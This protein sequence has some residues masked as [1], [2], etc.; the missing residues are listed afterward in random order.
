MILSFIV[1]L[2][3]PDQKALYVGLALL[4]VF[5]MCELS[6]FF[7]FGIPDPEMNCVAYQRALSRFLRSLLPAA[8]I[9]PQASD[10]ARS[11]DPPNG[12]SS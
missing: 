11:L 9:N 2:M 7:P 12:I 6:S 4:L 10:T 5:P 3:P 1:F 8:A